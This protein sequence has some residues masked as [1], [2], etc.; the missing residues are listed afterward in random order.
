MEVSG[1]NHPWLLYAQGKSPCYPLYRRLDGP[2]S[3]P[4]HG[5]EEKISNSSQDLNSQ[6]S[7]L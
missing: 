5:G 3:R 6:S 1:Q 4:G 7:N 2:Q